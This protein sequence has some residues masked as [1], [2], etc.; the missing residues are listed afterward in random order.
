[1][2]SEIAELRA[3]LP[4]LMLRDQRRLGRRVGQAA[5]LREPAARERALRRV[6]DDMDQAQAR[7]EARRRR[8]AGAS[9]TRPSCRSASSR[10][11]SPR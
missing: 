1:M 3:R 7:I 6:A 10:T 11:R 2:P 9:A 8:R 4:G 5:G